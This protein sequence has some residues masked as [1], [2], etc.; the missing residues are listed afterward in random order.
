M[1]EIK[2]DEIS[3]L[4]H[5]LNAIYSEFANVILKMRTINSSI[6]ELQETFDGLIEKAESNER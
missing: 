2:W 3:D 6:K 1:P 5:R 4:T